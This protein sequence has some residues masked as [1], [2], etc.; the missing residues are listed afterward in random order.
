MR[1]WPPD[2]VAEE[3]PGLE[4]LRAMG[5]RS[6]ALEKYCRERSVPLR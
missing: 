4:R 3:G 2:P 5:Y 6:H 1:T